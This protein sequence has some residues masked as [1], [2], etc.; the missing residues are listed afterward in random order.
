MSAAASTCTFSADDLSVSVTHQLREGQPALNL[1]TLLRRAVELLQEVLEDDQGSDSSGELVDEPVAAAA[2]VV[3]PQRPAGLTP[4]AA[5]AAVIRACWEERENVA[6]AAGRAAA[7]RIAGLQV[8][9][10]DSATDLPLRVYCV[11]RDLHD[12]VHDPP[13]VIQGWR[14]C[15]QHVQVAPRS[16]GTSVFRGFPALR[17][18]QAFAASFTAARR[19]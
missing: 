8:A 3:I 15:A 7:A 18:A 16:F 19:A 2:A 17:E 6:R 11:C 13:L 5:S 10:V 1:R 12:T 14:H 9:A 4:P